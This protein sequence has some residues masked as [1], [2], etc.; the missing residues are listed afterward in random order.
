MLARGIALALAMVLGVALPAAA[1]TPRRLRPTPLTLDVVGPRT[2]ASV[3]TALR[4]HEGDL[5]ECRP[6]EGAALVWVMLEIA[7]DGSVVSATSNE[8]DEVDRETTECV[9]RVAATWRFSARSGDGVTSVAWSF[10]LPPPIGMTCWCHRWVHGPAFGQTCTT[11]ERSCERARVDRG[12]SGM[13]Q[14][15]RSVV[16]PVCSNTGSV[17]HP[18]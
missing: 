9:M 12:L 17:F 7:P 4:A 5:D 11:T 6:S 13:S 1:Q 16:L 18:H 2:R 10:R 14:P 8:D 15:C 3:R